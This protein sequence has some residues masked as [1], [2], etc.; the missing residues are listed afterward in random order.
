MSKQKYHRT[1]EASALV[2]KD[3]KVN[4]VAKSIQQFVDFKGL[5]TSGI[6]ISEEALPQPKDVKGGPKE[7]V[8]G[9]KDQADIQGNIIP[10]FN[11]GRQQFLFFQFGEKKHAKKFLQHLLPYVSTMKEVMDFRKIYRQ[12]RLRLGK[13]KI[14]L[15]A[16]VL[17]VAFS[18]NGIA[19]L[20]KESVVEE[21]GDPGFRIGMAGRSSFLGDPTSRGSSGHPAKWKFGGP[22][23]PVDLAVIVGSDSSEQLGGLVEVVKNFAEECAIELVYEQYGQTLPGDLRGHEHFGFRDGISQPGVRGKLS[24]A[25]GDYITPRYI[26]DSDD[27]RLYFSKPGQLLVWPGQF[28]LGEPRQST[29]D[30]TKKASNNQDNFPDWAKRGSYLVVRRLR[31]DVP[32]FWNFVNSCAKQLGIEPVK[33]ASQIVGRWPSGAPIMRSPDSENTSLGADEFANNHF[34]F[35]DDT[36]ASNL[37]SIPGYP[38]DNFSQAK[39]DFL[40]K[41]CP[42][43]AHIRKVNPRESVTDLGKPEDNLARAILRRGIPYGEPIVGQDKFSKRDATADR[44]LMFLCY[45][46]SIEDQF[47]FLQRRWSNSASQPNLGGFDPIIGQN[48]DPGRERFIEFPLA[49][50][51]VTRIQFKEDFVIP[52]GGEYFFAPTISAIKDVLAK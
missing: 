4:S 17:N 45:N 50:G 31:Q 42:H 16:T 35:D 12:R 46:A 44:G 14:F 8:Y 19:K 29:E 7:P 37:K 33:F 30:L 10:G 18:R 51:K 24:K 1:Y 40:A 47:E 25:P 34:I 9:E 52:T 26:D 49:D 27:R 48:G 6:D 32:A 36:S 5:E 2:N 38:G 43:F 41:V 23:R 21:F 13:S 11:K 20:M 15:C 22:E 3:I 28:L 39:A